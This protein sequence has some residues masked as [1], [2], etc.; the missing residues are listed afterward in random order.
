MVSCSEYDYIEIVCMYQYPIRL[1]MK[2]GR[3]VECKA[4]NTRYDDQRQECIQVAI[5]GD[6]TLLVL[7]DVSM[8]E[9]LI[10][11]PHFKKVSFN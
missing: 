5:E 6:E 2:S 10:E 11:N 4:L 7:D 3:V 8:L 1:T 9:V